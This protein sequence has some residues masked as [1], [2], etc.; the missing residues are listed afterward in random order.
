M[1]RLG[2]LLVLGL[3]LIGVTA[4]RAADPALVVIVHPDRAATLAIDEVGRIYRGRRRFW[5]DGSAIVAL[6]LPSG[7]SLRERFSQRV[8]HGDSAQ[9][10]AYWNEQYFHGLF[11]PT[12]L[13]S[14]DAVKRYVASDPK[15]IGYIEAADVD[16]S[17]RVVLTLE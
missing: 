1:R 3:V 13:S 14:G 11:P 9:L 4:G 5:D 15:A 8:L 17:V 6:N 7:T 12:V 2:I 16:A 10:A